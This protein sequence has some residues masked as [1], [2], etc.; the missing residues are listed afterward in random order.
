MIMNIREEEIVQVKI[1]D[2]VMGYV[3]LDKNKRGTYF[4]FDEK[5]LNSG[6]D[7]APILMPLNESYGK[8]YSSFDFEH[9]ID[10][11][12]TFKY[13]VPMIS[14]SLPDDFGNR[15]FNVWLKA[16]NIREITPVE[17][18]IFVGN[19]GMGALEFEPLLDLE[20]IE[21]I[22][23]KELVKIVNNVL[24]N[25]KQLVF[26][27]L[28]N[29]SLTCILR[30]GTSA[31]GAKPKA[32][33]AINNKTNE[34][35]PGDVV[36][37]NKNF[38]YWIIKLDGL[39]KTGDEAVIKGYGKIEYVYSQMAKLA[40]IN[41]S[42]TKLLQEGTRSHFMTKR[43]DRTENGNKIHMQTLGALAG[44][45]YKKPYKYS[46]EDALQI[47]MYLGL[48]H[49]ELEEQYRRAVFNIIARNQDDHIKNISFLMD[50]TGQWSLSP[51]YDISYAFNPTGT[52]TAEHQLSFNGKRSNF[53]QRDFFEVAKKFNIKNPKR[54]I[55]QVTEAVNQ[56]KKLA[57]EVDI[58]QHQIK[59]ISNAQR[60]YLGM[61]KGKGI[62][63]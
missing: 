11:E 42:E 14:E 24:Y 12:K 22:E 10:F 36:Y 58:P 1:Y 19:G 34:V 25:K 38:S 4:K 56:W 33:I 35:K 20:K 30:V 54:I 17:R 49:K 53:E 55:E 9:D 27:G 48:S 6:L 15:M 28:D 29:K 60:L 8:I 3:W 63:F 5:F 41:M 51:A 21:N 31:G 44:L 39:T 26:D 43:F 47:I 7:V 59:K 40:G 13:L 50:K 37:K 32:V 45:S 2:K 61:N 23:I 62:Q 57:K 16:K 18:L 52:W 46:Y